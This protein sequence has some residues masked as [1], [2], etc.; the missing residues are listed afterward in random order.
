[1]VAVALRVG[2]DLVSVDHVEESVRV[3][4]GRYLQRVYTERGPHD[5]TVPD[6]APDP[7]RLGARFAAKEA[8]LKVLR[9]ADEAV[10]WR[11]IGVRSGAHGAPE[12]VLAG[13]AARLA[14]RRG[15]ESLAV[16]LTHEGPFAAA[17]V[18]ANVRAGR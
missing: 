9:S 6:G 16:S 13:A 10:P 4:A 7:Q 15:I 17:I 14:R 12:I 3:H 5:C 8:T 1:V 18:V 2:I 11:T